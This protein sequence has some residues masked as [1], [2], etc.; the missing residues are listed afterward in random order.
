MESVITGKR[1]RVL[2]LTPEY[3][4]CGP[5]FGIGRYTHD[6][7]LGL[8]Q[9]GLCV[10][11]LAATDQGVFL[12]DECG[13]AH[14][15]RRWRCGLL[16]RPWRCR[17]FIERAVDDFQ[18]Q[19][20]EAPNWGALSAW[21]SVPVPIVVRASSSV[22]DPG[23]PARLRSW[24]LAQER[25]AVRRAAMLIA[26]SQ[27][28]AA[29]AQRLYGRATD[30]V[31]PHAWCGMLTAREQEP[32]EEAVLFVGRAEPRKGLDVL[33]AAWP[34]VRRA[35]PSAQLHV[36]TRAPP[37]AGIGPEHGLHWHRG[38][39]DA[40]LDAL[41]R[42]CRV[43]AVPS[44]WE[45]FGLVV[46]E[47]WAAGLAVVASDGGA[48]PEVVGDAGCLVPVGDAPAL[49]AAVIQALDPAQALRLAA[50]GRQR[51][52][53]AFDGDAWIEANLRVYRR[54]LTT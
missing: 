35:R 3:P 16:L 19:L 4:G 31:I 46:L 6:L 49:A 43:Q 12:E 7:A 33:L 47:A 1:L 36:V 14:C 15:L 41:R 52:K 5:S 18:P 11:V 25:R 38:L 50:V 32:R 34:L 17:P 13:V 44:R 27:A 24:R 2:F 8:R 54:A 26:D 9:R 42:R 53:L 40:D 48:L 20:V 28:M 22:A 10:R 51:L 23:I 29:A 45:S 21:L 37:I 39:S 30:A